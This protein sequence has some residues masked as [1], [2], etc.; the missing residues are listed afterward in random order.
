MTLWVIALAG[1]AALAFNR[2]QDVEASVPKS[3]AGAGGDF[4]GFLQGARQIAGGHALYD[5]RAVSQGYGYVYTPLVAILLLPFSH[6]ATATVWHAW[7]AASL[8]AVVLF[9][10][11]VTLAQGPTV[12][13]WRRPLLFGFT[14]FTALEF[15][16]TKSEITSGQTDGFVLVFLA[17]A[18]LASERERKALSGALVAVG[19]LVKTWPAAAALAFLRRGY[20]RRGRAFVGWALVLVLGPVMAAA[21]NGASGLADFF[22]ITFAARSQNLVSFSVWTVPRLLFS[23]SG[24]ARPVFVSTPVRYGAALVLAGSVVA[25]LVLII[26]S[27]ESTI[28]GF[29]NV[30]G[31]VVLLLPVAH[32]D[33]TLYFL[34]LLWIWASRSLASSQ[35][36]GVAPIVTGVLVLWWLVL[37]HKNY[38]SYSPSESSLQ[39]S[40][41]FVVNFAAVTVSVL[42]DH[43]RTIRREVKRTPEELS[44]TKA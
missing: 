44:Y 12:R 2:Y 28:L 3:A 31:C 27:A 41:I 1:A 9:G 30:V 7:T 8:F 17:L 35:P 24:L 39:Y 5:F 6:A 16:P 4:W 43:L 20:A 26:R 25:L 36:H 18:V 15:V 23:R 14:A 21:V 37:F 40:V 10:G 29:W 11:L 38:V 19:G 32:G 42:G 22:R 33:Y 13:S 34:P